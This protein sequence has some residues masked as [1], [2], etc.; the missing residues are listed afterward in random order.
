M[1][2]FLQTVID[3]TL[4]SA[5]AIIV[6]AALGIV[7]GGSLRAILGSPVQY[8]PVL[9]VG[10]VLQILAEQFAIPG[11]TSLLV[12]GSFL[13]VLAAL[14][15]LHLKGVAVTG[16]GVTLNFAAVVANGH[17]PIRFSSLV[18]AGE[19][20]AGVSA[21]RVSVG[22]LWQLETADTSLP[23]LGDIVP[24]SFLGDVVSFG[25]LIMIGGLTVLTMNLVLHRRRVGID[26]DELLGEPL[27]SSNVDIRDLIDLEELPVHMPATLTPSAERADSVSEGQQA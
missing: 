13:L 22:G 5:A 14:L 26:L 3:G 17:I 11:R 25:D 27:D 8:W 6:G 18:A 19:V 7:R 23:Q 4:L 1:P 16:I 24:I 21:D 20:P 15:N 2:E 10:A 9:A 12:I